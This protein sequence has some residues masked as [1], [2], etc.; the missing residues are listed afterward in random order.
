[1]LE[2]WMDGFRLA[3]PCA[4][5]PESIKSLTEDDYWELRQAYEWKCSAEG[6]AAA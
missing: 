2:P 4:N 6:E 1:M 5:T 3:R